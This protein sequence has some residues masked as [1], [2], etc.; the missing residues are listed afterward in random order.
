MGYTFVFDATTVN[1]MPALTGYAFSRK[2]RDSYEVCPAYFYSFFLSFLCS[3]FDKFF[4]QESVF[5]S[6]LIVDRVLIHN[7]I[8]L[9]QYVK[10]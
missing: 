9:M 10:D 6:Y 7:A 4:N 5:I 1:S 2:L 3:F 8:M